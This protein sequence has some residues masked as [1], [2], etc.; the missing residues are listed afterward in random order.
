L[1][2]FEEG[3]AALRCSGRIS[4]SVGVLAFRWLRDKQTLRSNS[5]LNRLRQKPALLLFALI[6][7]F[8]LAHLL[9]SHST[10]PFFYNDETRHVMTGVYFRD[11]LHDMPLTHLREYTINYYLQYPALTCFNWFAARTIHLAP[12]WQ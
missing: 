1:A 6:L 5:M 8:G 2:H 11:L 4:A 10:E 7:A 3:A 9:V 12:R